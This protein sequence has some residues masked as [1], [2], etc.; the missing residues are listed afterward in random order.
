MLKLG[1]TGNICAGKS[2]A[3]TV[4][5]KNGIPVI[6]ADEIVHSLLA[7]DDAVI[8]QVKEL[9]YP[10]NLLDEN[11]KID[12]KL[13]GQLVFK[14]EQKRKE[15]EKIL[16]PRV[17][18][19]IEEFFA[20]NTD[21]PI[22]V[23]SLALLFEAE[24]TYLFDKT[25][26]IT[27]ENQ[28]QIDRLMTRNNYNKEQALSRINAQLPQEEKIKKAD[29]VIKNNELIEKFEEKLNIFIKQQQN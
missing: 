25:L 14:D 6:D 29:F 2:I 17:I 3:E 16:H 18:A 4:F 7:D 21:K 20:N 10:N 13:L 11:N 15:L 5:K 12:R 19:L 9:F 22:A 24:L 26:L 1:L 27:V 8:Q 28:T 23:A